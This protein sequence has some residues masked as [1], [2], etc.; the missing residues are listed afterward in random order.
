MDSLKIKEN[1]V[2]FCL[3]KVNKEE[4]IRL[5]EKEIVL[6][7]TQNWE[8]ML[9]KSRAFC[10]AGAVSVIVFLSVSRDSF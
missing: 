6:E 1:I 3:K 7:V 5:S 9:I 4:K 8:I 10:E 2:Q